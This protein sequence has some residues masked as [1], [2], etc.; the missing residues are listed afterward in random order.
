M[1]DWLQVKAYELVEET[2]QLGMFGLEEIEKYIKDIKLHFY[3]EEE[4]EQFIDLVYEKYEKRKKYYEVKDIKTNKIYTF[5]R[6]KDFINTTN[7]PKQNLNLYINTETIICARFNIKRKKFTNKELL[8][9]IK[10]IGNLNEI[11]FK[12]NEWKKEKEVFKYGRFH[13]FNKS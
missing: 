8:D 13:K 10:F 7:I 1:R 5:P 2:C 11:D 3:N 6:L 12:Y 4:K 9:G